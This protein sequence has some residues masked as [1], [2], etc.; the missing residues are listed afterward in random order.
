MRISGYDEDKICKI[1]VEI[2]YIEYCSLD[3]TLYFEDFL[4]NDYIISGINSYLGEAILI[5]LM[6]CGLYF[7]DN[8]HVIVYQEDEE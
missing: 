7:L 2:N 1:A 5:E 8:D 3:D 4:G 6:D